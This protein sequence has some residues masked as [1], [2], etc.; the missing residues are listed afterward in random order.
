MVIPPIRGVTIFS[1]RRG[2]MSRTR[3]YCLLF[4]AIL[5]WS[6]PL[7]PWG[8]TAHKAVTKNAI[9]V[10]P[11]VI[12]P[13]L[14]SMSD[15]LI[16][17]SV[18]PD[19]I[20]EENPEE[21]PHHYIDIDYY[22]E[23]PFHKLPRD[24]TA[25]VRKFSEDTVRQYGTLPWRIAECVDSLSEAIRAGDRNRIVKWAAYLSH[26]VTDAHQPLHTVLNYNGQLTGNDGIHSRYETGMVDRYFDRY[27]FTPLAV[28]SMSNP[29]NAAFEI[30]L[31]SYRLNDAVIGADNYATLRMSDAEVRSLHE[32]W[33]LQADSL[34]FE[35][36]Y[37]VLG[38]LT[39]ERLDL[40]GARLAM[41][42]YTAWLRAGSPEL[43]VE[44]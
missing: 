21:G 19:M 40:A 16:A 44:K 31:E 28:E 8:F 3:L 36:L 9:T 35:R 42:W 2:D 1:F 15:S 37:R 26:Y 39:W 4:L 24:Y 41:L 34:Y 18:E 5:S 43:P 32:H 29:R 13:L 38:E 12:R 33:D 27:E 6:I 30:V 17:R 10:T 25:A 14:Q 7:Y 20:R 23:Y 11:E 22:G